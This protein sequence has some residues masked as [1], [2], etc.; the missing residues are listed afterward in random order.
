MQPKNVPAR[1]NHP[2]PTRPRCWRITYSTGRPD[3]DDDL[4]L[5]RDRD[6]MAFCE[7]SAGLPQMG[8]DYRKEFPSKPLP[9]TPEFVDAGDY[10]EVRVLT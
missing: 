7:L 6:A 3:D 9:L 5:F 4:K 8:Y 1:K 2:A 10:V